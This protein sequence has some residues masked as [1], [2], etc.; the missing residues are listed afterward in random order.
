MP[1]NIP[2]SSLVVKN[3][4]KSSIQSYLTNF[5]PFLKGSWLGALADSF[6]ERVYDFFNAIPDAIDEVFID[7]AVD[8][9]ERIGANH[10]LSPNAA[11]PST[12]Y[13]IFQSTN[14][15]ADDPVS[16]GQVFV[17]GNGNEYVA[18]ESAE[19]FGDSCL[20]TSLTRSGTVATF[21][22]DRNHFLKSGQ[23]VTILG[24]SV[25]AYNG[26]K[27]IQVVS[28]TSFTFSVDGGA[29]TPATGASFVRFGNQVKVNSSSVGSAVN[30]DPYTTVSLQSPLV[31]INDEC[32]VN[33]EG[34]KNGQDRESTEQFRARVLDYV[35]NPIAHF[36]NSEISS[37][38]KTVPGITRVII[39]GA[40]PAIGQ[41]TIYPMADN[42]V[43]P[44]PSSAKIDDVKNKLL[45]IMP[46]NMSA[47]D[48]IVSAAGKEVANFTFTALTPNTSTMKASII[49]SLRQFFAESA[50]VGINITQ[51][52]Y[53]AVIK[54]TIDTTNGDI[55]SSFTLSSPL[56][57][58]TPASN[59]IP[60]LGSVTFL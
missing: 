47:A 17:D 46:V 40:T 26:V 11:S 24:A 43:D 31:N 15:A 34:L 9:L 50:N 51:D 8:N 58:I 41:V 55:V 30:L 2:E 48:L 18:S 42:D 5:N 39:K 57:S 45:T 54:T 52:D 21:A 12:G 53:R 3:R 25:A 20:A 19:A 37:L 33:S 23:Q 38:A 10:N 28:D 13:I 56:G 29:A 6:S 49:E 1:I 36:N 4:V 22:G 7:S 35:R 27:T 60:V 59:E 32:F 44:V 14:T 16:I